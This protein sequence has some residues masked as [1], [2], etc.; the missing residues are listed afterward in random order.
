[1]AKRIPLGNIRD[2]LDRLLTRSDDQDEEIKELKEM[3]SQL[4]PITML[5]EM[6]YDERTKLDQNIKVV[7]ANKKLLNAVKINLDQ[8]MQELETNKHELDELKKDLTDLKTVIKRLQDIANELRHE[9]SDMYITKMFVDNDYH[10][11][12]GGGGF[13]NGSFSH[14][15]KYKDFYDFATK[16]V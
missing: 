14:H 15:K 5:E 10:N 9:I 11:N 1:M 8:N 6:I 16:G 2:K 3:F 4:P 7:N 13:G 12:H